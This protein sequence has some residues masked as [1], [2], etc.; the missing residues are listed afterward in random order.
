MDR[1]ELIVVFIALVGAAFF[2][3]VWMRRDKG[4]VPRDRLPE[5]LSEPLNGREGA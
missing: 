2:L 5:A 1:N 4:I 3:A